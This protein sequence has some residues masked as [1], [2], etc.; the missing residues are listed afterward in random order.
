LKGDRTPSVLLFTDSN[1][2]AGTEQHILTLARALRRLGVGAMVGCPS[3]AILSDRARDEG[4]PVLTIQKQ[5]FVDFQAAGILRREMGSGT[6]SLVHAHNSR[7]ALAAAIAIRTVSHARLV[8]TQHFLTPSHASR[9]GVA[10]H[11]FRLA[12]KWMNSRV[13]HFIAVSEEAKRRMVE[14][15]GV[16]PERITV[17]PNGI[18]PELTRLR[19][20]LDVRREIGIG[21]QAPLAVCVSR[22]E[23]EKDVGTLVQAMA[24]VRRELPDAMCV[25]VGDGSQRPALE[26]LTRQEGL[27]DAVRFAGHLPDAL[28]VIGAGDLL[29][30]PSAVE[31]F[32]LVVLEAMALG[33]AVIATDAGGPR[34]IVLN[35]ETGL[36]VPPQN[37]PAIAKAMLRLLSDRQEAQAM[38]E[39]GRRRFLERYTAER[40]AR[41]TIEVYRRVLGEG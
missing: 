3:P 16:S 25:I 11:L 12:H 14:R 10:R 6:F 17:I 35:G 36:L 22:L 21:E 19:N 5:G 20:P 26:S 38:G 29:V 23:K 37:P 31:S 8:M 2:F 32:G 27:S 4:L 39:Q 13:A 9:R 40:M 41:E 28:S 15:E 1:V 24:E 18:A 33:K 30:L 7:T 34:E